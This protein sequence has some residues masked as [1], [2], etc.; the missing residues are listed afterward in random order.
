MGMPPLVSYATLRLRFQVRIN[1]D[2]FEF[3]SILEQMQQQNVGHSI[4]SLF[5]EH[6]GART[7]ELSREGGNRRTNLV[8]VI[9]C[10]LFLIVLLFLTVVVLVIFGRRS[11]PSLT[12]P[13]AA[14]PTNIR[15]IVQI[16]PAPHHP[17]LQSHCHQRSALPAPVLPYHTLAVATPISTPTCT[18]VEAC[19]LSVDS[20]TVWTSWFAYFIWLNKDCYSQMSARL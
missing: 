16:P 4:S 12:V 20:S 6:G 5:D 13:P 18:F 2:N 9:F 11:R 1:H 8:F 15:S 3:P 17:F 7:E 14:A 19:N 10:A